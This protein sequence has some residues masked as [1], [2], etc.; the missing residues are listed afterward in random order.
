M[1][2]WFQDLFRNVQGFFE[3]FRVDDESGGGQSNQALLA[4]MRSIEVECYERTSRNELVAYGVYDP[5]L[6][7]NGK[8]EV[9]E[10]S[11]DE[12]NESTASPG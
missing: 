6:G 8:M 4:L 10:E 2:E 3:R 7:C 12:F 9:E 11:H 5:S 1:R